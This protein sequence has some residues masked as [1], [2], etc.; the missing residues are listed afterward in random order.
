M[1]Y[2]EQRAMTLGRQIALAESN[3]QCTMINSHEPCEGPLERHHIGGRGNA[4]VYVPELQIIHCTH[5][6][7]HALFAPHN[8]KRLYLSWLELNWPEKYAWY[9]ELKDKVVKKRDMDMKQICEDL[10]KRADKAMYKV[11]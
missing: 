11:A 10:Q 3:Y 6:H 1:T 7:H 4:C 8:N 9:M 5:H 2:Y